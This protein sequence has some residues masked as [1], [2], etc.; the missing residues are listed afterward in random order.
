MTPAHII[1]MFLLQLEHDAAQDRPVEE[2]QV[3]PTSEATSKP[4]Q[5]TDAGSE[6]SSVDASSTVN[7]EVHDV[8]EQEKQVS[9][10]C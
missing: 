6:N 3:F 8:L 1:F 9:V 4:A 10:F 2:D 7:E 5:D